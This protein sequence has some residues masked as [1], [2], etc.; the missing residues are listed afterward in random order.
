MTDLA[1]LALL[2]DRC[3]PALPGVVLHCTTGTRGSSPC[4]S[5]GPL[6]WG[7]YRDLIY[8]GQQTAE[9]DFVESC[10][11]LVVGREDARQLPPT[12]TG[13]L[14]AMA[15]AVSRRVVLAAG[16]PFTFL[17]L[18]ASA[19]LQPPLPATLLHFHRS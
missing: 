5:R 15:S 7:C 10:R 17:L 12:T 16:P 3:R 2:V 19:L 11:R 13:R 1:A 4:G 9:D 8:K 14:L 6:L 18:L